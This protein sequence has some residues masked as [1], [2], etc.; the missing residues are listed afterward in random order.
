MLR[1][2]VAFHHH[3]YFNKLFAIYNIDSCLEN[4]GEIGTILDRQLCGAV[5]LNKKYSNQ[6]YDLNVFCVMFQVD[7]M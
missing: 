7:Y 6:I 4:F 2:G 1:L 3:L 5:L